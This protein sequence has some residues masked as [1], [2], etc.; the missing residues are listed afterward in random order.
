MLGFGVLRRRGATCTSLSWGGGN[1]EVGGFLPGMD[2]KSKLFC[3][4]RGIEGGRSRQRIG[5]MRLLIVK[6]DTRDSESP[7]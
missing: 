7:A 2:G 5:G 3:A 4:R 1:C 6:K